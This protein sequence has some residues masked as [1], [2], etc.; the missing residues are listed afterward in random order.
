MAEKRKKTYHFHSEWE[1]EFFFTTVKDSCVCLICGATVATAKRH[2]VER[3]FR[4]CHTSYH[5][6]YTK[7][8]TLRAEKA[9]KLKAGLS[10]QQSFF[11]RPVK[12][13]QKATEAS[14]R[15]THF[16]IKKKKAFLDE[17]VFKEAVMIIAKTVL[18][19]EKYGNDVIS[20]LSDVQLG[21]T[22]IVRRVSAM[23]GNLAD[24]LDQDLSKCRWFS[25]QCDESVDSSSTAQLMVFIRMVFDG[26]STKEELL[27]LLPLK[28]TTK[29]IDIYNAVKEFFAKKKVPLEKLVSVT[30]DKAP[31]MIGRH[32]GFIA[33][34]K[35]DTEFPNFM[36]YHC[37]IHQQALCAKVI[38]FEHVMTPVLKIINSIR[39]RAKQHRTFKVLLEELSAEYGDLL[40]HTEI[41]WLSRGRILLRF[42]SLLG[43]IKEFMQSKGEDTSLLEDTEWTL[44]LAFLTDI[45]GKLNHLNCELQGKGKTVADMISALNGFKAQ[46]SIFSVHLQRK[47]VLHFPSVQMVLKDNASASETFDKVA[48]KYTQVINRLGQEFENRFCDLD[49]LEPCVSFV[50]IP[51]MNVDTTCI[52]E[53]L[54]S[55][56]SLDAGQVEIEIVTLQN[57]VHL[58]AYQGAPNFWCLV[59]TEKYSGVCTAAMKV[60]SLFGSTYLCESAFSDMNF[61]KNKH[62]TRLSDAHLQ[63]SLRVAVSSYTPDY[64]TLVNSMQCQVS[65]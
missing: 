47:K 37:I 64:N 42:L 29:G 43:E 60:A 45:T 40:L 19:D 2:N 65:H 54:S 35:G 39:S 52:A 14:F 49:Q 48:E 34:C 7:G 57:D 1:E 20:T 12:S 18:K 44:D 6:N 63:D 8:G 46:M 23:S 15:A 5:A 4:T 25:I 62:R 51:F 21:A 61:I 59:D 31:A 16:M 41:R 58:K 11:T 3:H 32:T 30:T 22:T 56:F 36:H 55:M 53:Q 9:R 17:E 33:H 24:Q 28:T 13:S 10:K 27:T 38:G 50:S 26:F